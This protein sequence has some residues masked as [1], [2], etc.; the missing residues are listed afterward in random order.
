MNYN[1]VILP[2]PLK[3]IG[4][5]FV[6]GV[7]T[8]FFSF[9]GADA[10]FNDISSN[11]WYND[12]VT[13]AYV[14]GWFNGDEHGNFNPDSRTTRAQAAKVVYSYIYGSNIPSEGEQYIDTENDAWYLPYTNLNNA[15]Q[16]IPAYGVYFEPD[17]YITRLDTVIAILKI[18][19][20]NF[21]NADIS[22]I[23]SY[24]DW[25]NTDPSNRRY[26]AAAI[27]YGL[28][29]GFEDGTLK[30]N[31]P[32]TRAQFAAFMS[33]GCSARWQTGGLNEDGE[34]YDTERCLRT[35]YF[36]T[37]ACM[38]KANG[39]YIITFAHYSEDENKNFT[40]SSGYCGQETY[41]PPGCYKLCIYTESNRVVDLSEHVN[42]RF[43]YT[44]YLEQRQLSIR[45]IAHRGSIYQAPE[46]TLA[47]FAKAADK[48]YK[49]VECDIRWTKDNIPMLLHDATIDSVSNGKGKLCDMTYNE[50]RK[51]DFGSKFSSDFKG[52]VIASYEEFIKLCRDRG[53]NPYVEVYD[54][55]NFTSER[56]RQ[57]M[58]IAAKYG[59]ENRITWISS[60]LATLEKIKNASTVYDVR[61][62]YIFSLNDHSV[63]WR[64]AK[65]KTATNRVGLDVDYKVIDRDY[66]NFIKSSGF[67]VEAWTVNDYNTAINLINMGVT[68]ITTD[69]ISPINQ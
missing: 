22:C 39:D 61:L 14:K 56:A 34:I 7:L 10:F 51:Y 68:G 62:L 41:L 11:A 54:G 65:L 15:K 4:A 55:E 33:R 21:S 59:M 67:E 25:E 45:T 64:L 13:E 60:Y 53:L 9:V 17:I 27:Q 6:I 49:N 12:Y 35:D 66:V 18:G 36:Y 30:M 43:D 23:Y 29:T 42:I 63:K 58:D 24:D 40:Y 19:G 57:L 44:P 50:V 32:V 1:K 37:P 38:V 16:I 20:I 47:A 52:T 2:A 46:N 28:I 48:G 5:A 3:K 26:V 31:A 8:V 69:S